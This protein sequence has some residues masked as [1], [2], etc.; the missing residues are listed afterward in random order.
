MDELDR[1]S[2]GLIDASDHV[3]VD[4]N[5]NLETV[6]GDFRGKGAHALVYILYNVIHRH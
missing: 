1:S 2:H 4:F 3:F 5:L 6:K